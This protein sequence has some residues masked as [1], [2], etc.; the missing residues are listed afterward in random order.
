MSRADR[1]NA[2]STLSVAIQAAALG[3]IC[4]LISLL[5]FDLG[6]FKA[7]FMFLPLTVLFYW[8]RRSAYA[9]SL[10]TAGLI[11]LMQDLM[12]G[13]PLG[14]WTLTFVILFILIDPTVRRVRYGFLSQWIL[15]GCLIGAGVISVF[16]L[17]AITLGQWPSVGALMLNALVGVMT[18]PLLFIAHGLFHQLSGDSDERRA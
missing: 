7:S 9:S 10:W 12:S 6:G 8:P 11:G 13:G 17:G 4:V 2:L 14:L 16:I 3:L 18:F 5:S 15:F 1:S